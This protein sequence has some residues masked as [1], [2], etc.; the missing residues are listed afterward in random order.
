MQIRVEPAAERDLDRLP[1]VI[2][3][4]L[5]DIF[6]RLAKWPQVSG[7]KPLDDWAGHYRIRTG[8]WRIIFRIQRT[9]VVIVRI[10]HRSKVYED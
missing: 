3:E 7:A 5:E 10:M 4:R 2:L 8:D 6:D 1:R 9:E